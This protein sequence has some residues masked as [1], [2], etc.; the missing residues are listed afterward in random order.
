MGGGTK[1]RGG[2]SNRML[3]LGQPL[4]QD[5]QP[6]IGFAA[7]RARRGARRPRA[8]TSG[9]GSRYAP[10]RS[11]QREQQRGGDVVGQV[12]DDLAR[13]L[14]RAPPGRAPARRRRRSRAGRDSAAASSPSAA[15]QRA[16]RSIATTWRAPSASSARVSPPGPGPIS[17]TLAS[18][19]GPAARAMRPVRLRSSRKF[20]PRLLLRGDAVPGDDLAQRRQRRRRT[21]RRVQPGGSRRV[22]RVAAISAASRSAAIRLSGA[23]DAACRRCRRRCRDRARC[24]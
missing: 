23:G 24:G 12:G 7:R 21:P 3:R 19:S 18:S 5:R 17:M 16:S 6:A 2:T 1:A 15:R 10:I 20:W 4:R 13:R 22:R 8:G 11:S 14:R 9:S